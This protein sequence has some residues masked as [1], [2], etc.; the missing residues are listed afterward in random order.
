MV[1]HRLIVI[2]GQS[3]LSKG[4]CGLGPLPGAMLGSL[5]GS[6]QWRIPEIL[7]GMTENLH[8]DFEMSLVTSTPA[9]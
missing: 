8:A 6:C 3:E 7:F 9:K 4:E 2:F 1:L 5:A